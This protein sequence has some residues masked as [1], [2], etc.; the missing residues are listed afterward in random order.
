MIAISTGGIGGV[1]GESDFSGLGDVWGIVR[2]AIWAQFAPPGVRAFVEETI[3]RSIARDR[4]AA[5]AQTLSPFE[6][7]GQTSFEENGSI[8]DAFLEIIE[9]PPDRA[10]GFVC[11]H[12]GNDTWL[13]RGLYEGRQRAERQEA[14]RPQRGPWQ[15]RRAGRSGGRDSIERRSSGRRR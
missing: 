14:R 11:V 2:G 12:S 6:D 3:E 10:A 5:L 7:F 15:G 9:E 4:E 1:R 13:P 8:L